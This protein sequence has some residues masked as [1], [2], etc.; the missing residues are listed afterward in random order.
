[1]VASIRN[2][3]TFAKQ[4]ERWLFSERRAPSFTGG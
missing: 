3:D 4:A 1:M 2:L